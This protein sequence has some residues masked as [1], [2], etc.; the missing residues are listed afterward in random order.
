MCGSVFP[1]VYMRVLVCVHTCAY[2]A[3]RVY[4]HIYARML[5][6]SVAKGCG[7]EQ[8]QAT[9]G[10]HE[11]SPQEPPWYPHFLSASLS[12]QDKTK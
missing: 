12:S 10:K 11:P 3:V 5:R 6:V 7:K 2:E 4:A 8:S 9:G 1:C